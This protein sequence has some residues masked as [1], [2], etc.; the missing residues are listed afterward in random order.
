MSKNQ[1]RSRRRGRPRWT[2]FLDGPEAL[3]NRLNFAGFYDP[4]K[5]MAEPDRLPPDATEFTLTDRFRATF[6]R[7]S[8]LHGDFETAALALGRSWKHVT[9]YLRGGVTIPTSVLTALAMAA[10]VS[11]EWLMTG[12]GAE[13]ADPDIEAI[14]TLSIRPSAG[15]GSYVAP[16][17]DYTVPFPRLLTANLAL[18]PEYARFMH[19]AGTS[20]S[21][22]IEDGDWL[23]VATDPVRR[24]NIRDGMIYMFSV[25]DS[26]YVK[27]LRRS[28][29]G[30]MMLSDNST[31]SEEL[32][33]PAEHFEVFGQ[34]VWVGR[35]LG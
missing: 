32:I 20:M 31:F 17:S 35:K 26:V 12:H 8:Q 16:E 33:P 5:P 21:P 23:L 7:Y 22:T 15:A 28:P 24:T 13:R 1:E 6:V 2:G 4:T 11:L 19:A 25:G 29:R 27:R 9:R 3:R 10:G 34:V 18:R 30:W 14:R